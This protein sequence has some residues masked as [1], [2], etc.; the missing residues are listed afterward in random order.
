MI[1]KNKYPNWELHH[2]TPER[3]DV[4]VKGR[5]IG[6]LKFR[7]DK[8][9]SC[10]LSWVIADDKEWEELK[11]RPLKDE[12]LE[13]VKYQEL[14]KNVRSGNWRKQLIDKES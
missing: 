11:I 8:F 3:H 13:E 1:D 5:S 12:E 4:M 2:Y 7:L 10:S 6:Y 14:I 9:V